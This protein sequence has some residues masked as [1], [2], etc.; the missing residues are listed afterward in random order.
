MQAEMR[1][2]KN[3][4][5][6][7]F[8]GTPEIAVPSLKK[9]AACAFV[10]VVGVGVLPD[11][12]EGRK[13]VLTPYPVKV[14][15]QALGLPLYEIKDKKDLVDLFKTETFDMGLVIAFGMLFPARILDIPK[16]GVVNVHFSLLPKY[17]G[18]S[19][20]QSAL[21]NHE[22]VSGITF[23]RMVRQ[24]D[25][26]PV[27][28]QKTFPIEGKK[29]SE[30]FSLFAREGA[31]MLPVFLDQ[32]FEGEVV[33]QKQDAR[34]V[35]TCGLLERQDGEVFPDR[36]TASTI[37]QKYLAFDVFPGIFV[38]TKKGNVKLTKMEKHPSQEAYVLR[39][40]D[41][42]VLYVLRAQIPGKKEMAVSEIAR[43]GAVFWGE[44]KAENRE[45]RVENNR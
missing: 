26:G 14:A 19:P 32:Y 35:T 20:V 12:K 43:G 36:E 8:F 11:K 9:L 15:A 37:F 29:A 5:K 13:Q 38:K 3:V 34:Q 16:F 10:Q 21:L 17:R 39:C 45:Q 33:F 18:A 42:T 1:S 7:F 2:A 44:Q 22:K 27:L 40:A 24:L 41:D 28:C 31:E 30:V 6:V 25:A 4:R 23:Q